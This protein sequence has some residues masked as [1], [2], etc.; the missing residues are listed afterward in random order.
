M[1]ANSKV[2]QDLSFNAHSACGYTMGGHQL[3]KEWLNLD[4]F[5]DLQLLESNSDYSEYVNLSQTDD[6]FVTVIARQ[7]DTM[8]MRSYEF[9]QIN[10]SELPGKIEVGWT[11][12]GWGIFGIVII[13]LLVIGIVASIWVCVWKKSKESRAVLQSE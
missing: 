9:Q 3:I 13:C 7:K 6:Y 4:K 8:T 12:G 11:L 2:K 1:L 10:M 5:E